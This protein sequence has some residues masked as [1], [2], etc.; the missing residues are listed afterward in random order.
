MIPMKFVTVVAG[1]LLI[2][3]GIF[4]Y[5]GG[6]ESGPSPEAAEISSESQDDSNAGGETAKSADA[7]S[8]SVAKS[9]KKGSSITALIPAGFGLLILICGF[10]AFNENLRKHAM[11]GALGIA[12]LGLIAG[13]A[14]LATKVGPMITGEIGFERPTIFVCL[15][16]LICL[17]F[18]VLGIQSFVA[19]RRA[20][21]AESAADTN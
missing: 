2:L 19:A 16:S 12:L 15:M 11:H 9:D 14:R 17:I 20:Q 3:L 21:S 7:K 6:G 1:A 13:I 10:V 4:G 18:L 5:L 8:D